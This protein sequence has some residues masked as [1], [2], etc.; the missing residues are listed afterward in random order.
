MALAVSLTQALVPS[1]VAADPSEARSLLARFRGRLSVHAAMENDALYP[2]L[3]GH[4]DPAVRERA[5]RL[6]DEVG[7]VYAAVN[8]HATRWAT[9]EAIQADPAQFVRETLEMLKALG[10]RMTRE[11]EQLY[12][13][14][15]ATAR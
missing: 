15:D 5:K 8:D 11:N 4:A 7:P 3:A 12:P 13:L 1:K 6:F 14:V 10:R 2:S 9:A